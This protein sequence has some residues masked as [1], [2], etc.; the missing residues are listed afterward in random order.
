MIPLDENKEENGKPDIA[1]RLPNPNWISGIVTA[2]AWNAITKRI[3][4]PI[5][6]PTDNAL[7]LFPIVNLSPLML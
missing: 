3:E 4:P 6:L 7:K 1:E 5:M 2:R